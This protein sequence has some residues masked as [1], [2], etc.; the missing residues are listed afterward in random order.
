M[1]LPS[2]V[3]QFVEWL[4]HRTG[5]RGHFHE[6][7]YENIP[8][9]AR[10]RYVSG[11]MLV[12]AFV[13]QAVTGIF[14]WMCYSPSSQTAYSSV[15]YIQHEM[16]GGWL[17]RGIHH[18]MAQ[19]MVVLLGV[20]LLQVIVDKAYQKP[21]EVNFW[22]GLIL[23]KIVLGLG[24]T[25]YLLPWDQKGYW[26]TNVAT[27][28]MTLV[29]VV[30]KQ[31]QQVVLGGGEYGHHTL[32]RFF[33]LHAGVLPALL[34]GFLGMHIAVFRRHGITAKI[35]TGRK[36]QFFWPHQVLL[37][38]VACLSLLTVVVL[39]CIHF[40]IFGLLTGKLDVAKR[41]AELGAPADASV[42]YSA[43]RPEWY[44]LF[45][46]QL[47]KYFQSEFVGAIVVPGAIFGVL[48]AAPLIARLK[49]GHS[50]VLAFVL[51]LVAGAGT[52]TFL[53]LDADSKD[54]QFVAA[55]H[56]A[57]HDA[58][59]V[60]ELYGRHEVVDG[61]SSGALKIPREGAV[62]LF[63]NDP[64]TQG[65]KL[66]ERHC[67]SCHDYVAPA[68]AEHGTAAQSV[69]IAKQFQEA[70]SKGLA[71]GERDEHRRVLRDEKGAVVYRSH[72]L[73]GANLF[74]FGTREWIRG[75]LD[76]DRITAVSYGEPE[77]GQPTKQRPSDHPDHFRR[78]I[79]SPYFGNTNH[80][81]GRM[82]EWVQNHLD[83]DKVD[84]D[85]VAAALSAQARLRS[86]SAADR[87]GG[88]LIARG[89][90]IIQETC[91]K[92]CH[93]FGDH[94]PSGL[95]PDLTGYGSYEWLMGFVSDPAH[96][97]FY[98]QENDRMP[99]FA[100]SLDNPAKNDVS[101]RELG[102]IVDWLRGE[103][104]V[105]SDQDPVLPHS[106]EQARR[107]VELARLTDVPR[108][109]LIGAAPAEPEIE[110]ARA[111]RLFHANC[112]AC[113][114]HVDANG[115]G[116][117]AANPSAP[118]LFQF[119]SRGWLAGLLDPKKVNEDAYFGNT[120]HFEGEMADFVTSLVDLTN[121]QKLALQQLIAAVS[122]EAALPYQAE[123]DA[124]AKS[125]GTLDKGRAAMKTAFGS[126]S[127]VG[128]HKFHDE[129]GAGEGYPDLTGW[130][131]AAWLKRMISD[132]SHVYTGKNDRMPAFASDKVDPAR[133][134]LP[135]ADIELLARFLRGE[136]SGPRSAGK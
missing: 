88:E 3:T 125:D 27:N 93:R 45:L 60:V 16:T 81:T 1:R 119:A 59:R 89:V 55:K 8:S 35:T 76:K 33:A 83:P 5:L 79:V 111:E 31:L 67:S 134:L 70:E 109:K 99:S 66:F 107:A 41:G 121:E 13:V 10:W 52:L 30:G 135:E 36:D 11:S 15:F 56:D 130:G 46:F 7:L 132:P 98:R 32:T 102:L 17:L 54:P 25:G 84:L 128:C 9:G 82:A 127:C 80:K 87:A 51:F 106:E 114:P 124:K 63:R 42:P 62:Y 104:Y 90:K 123:A 20:H 122:A 50:F 22:L 78:R 29:P 69:S 49:H 38:S 108:P 103:F 86:Q 71:P 95:A 64:Q 12:F 34:V 48:A 92:G 118:N 73:G 28:L 97:R 68:D 91:A 23:M 53:A 96:E 6:A 58:E 110:L 24:L 117:R 74:G 85:A 57:E 75:L 4:D 113:H 21:R 116:I 101:A 37:D 47:L 126:T 26:A 115:H 100:K 40:D 19:A 105:A 72:A 77:P 61:R 18:F 120:S 39:C 94:G 65:P 136:L 2:G 133:R 44:F 131:S 43:A 14:L 112:S 129:A